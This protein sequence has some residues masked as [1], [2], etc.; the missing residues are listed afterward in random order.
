[1]TARGRGFMRSGIATHRSIHSALKG[2]RDRHACSCMH[3]AV[4]CC[5][6]L[7]NLMCHLLLFMYVFVYLFCRVPGWCN[8]ERMPQHPGQAMGT[9]GDGMERHQRR[10]LDTLPC[11]QGAALRLR[12]R[13]RR[14][15][16]V[17]HKLEIKMAQHLDSRCVLV[18]GAKH[19][20][21]PAKKFNP[22]LIAFSGHWPR[23]GLSPEEE[24]QVSLHLPWCTC[25][26]APALMHLL[27]AQTFMRTLDG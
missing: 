25:L 4:T 21:N 27:L 14:E 1:M 24:A 10:G 15:R 7:H 17:K 26:G 11:N 9:G 2:I 23:L 12:A 6:L 16:P 20:S 22:H 13:E 8:E 19:F 5:E 18:L 3:Q